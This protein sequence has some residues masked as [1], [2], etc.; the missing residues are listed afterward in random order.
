MTAEELPDAPGFSFDVPEGAKN[1]IYRCR[2]SDDLAEMQYILDSD[3][4]CTRRQP[5]EEPKIIS[6]MFFGW[7]NEEEAHIGY[8]R[9]IGCMTGPMSLC[10]SGPAFGP[11]NELIRNGEPVLFMQIQA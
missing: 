5:M 2:K 9:R 7:E 6:G 1:V 10:L 3:E 4:F 8:I 11:A